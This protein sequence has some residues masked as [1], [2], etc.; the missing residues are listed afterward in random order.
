MNEQPLVTIQ[1]PIYNAEEY[2]PKLIDCLSN[3]TYKNIEVILIEDFSTDNS[4]QILKDY[5]EKDNRF[6]VI[7]REY[8]GGNTVTGIVY[9]LPYMNGKYWF[10][11]SQDD[12]IDYDLIEKCVEKAETTGAQMVCPNTML[13]WEG[14]NPEK[15]TNFPLNGDYN[16]TISGKDAFPLSLT[17]D[18]PGFVLELTSHLKESGI[19]A[20]YWNSCEFY[21]RKSLL[22]VERIAFANTNVYYRQ[23][24]PNAITKK[25]SYFS[26]DVLTT[27]IML[28]QL[29]IEN[30]YE[31]KLILNRTKQLI[32]G[33]GSWKRK[34]INNFDKF[35]D[36][37]KNYI[38]NSLINART[39]LYSIIKEQKYFIGY[40]LMISS[41]L[42]VK[43]KR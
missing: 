27:D 40:L 8:K 17:W 16:Y 26:F 34:F 24:N 10:Y 5:S 21:F 33:F 7:K 42:R 20:E 30:K 35:N 6:K 18:F 36:E 1:I 15:I 41:D 37:Q 38:R 31:R 12:F 4:F 28:L 9:A 13:Y 43:I 39:N 14:K 11:L 19:K 2:I 3:Q 32:R 25:L 22:N 29:L 23:D